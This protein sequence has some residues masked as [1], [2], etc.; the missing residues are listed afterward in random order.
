MSRATDLIETLSPE[1]RETAERFLPMFNRLLEE[2]I[3]CWVSLILGGDIGGAYSFATARMT[4]EEL[5]AEQASICV[6]MA[7]LNIKNAEAISAQRARLAE[8]MK[9][10]V[11]LALSAVE[12]S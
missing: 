11:L 10:T 4:T 9:A 6:V 1:L 2:E 3:V 7:A 5:V 8:F 12:D